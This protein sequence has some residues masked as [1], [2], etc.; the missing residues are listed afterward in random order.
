MYTTTTNRIT[1]AIVETVRPTMLE[2]YKRTTDVTKFGF[3]FDAN[4]QLFY[5]R[6][7]ELDDAVQGMLSC[8]SIAKFRKEHGE[9]IKSMGFLLD[10]N[11]HLVPLKA[12]PERFAELM[13][14][15]LGDT[16]QLICAEDCALKACLKALDKGSNEEIRAI[17]TFIESE[18]G[19][20]R[21]IVAAPWRIALSKLYSV[22]IDKQFAVD[23]L[24]RA[25]P[26][27]V[28][29]LVMVIN[30][31]AKHLRI[32]MPGDW[33]DNALKYAYLL[34]RAYYA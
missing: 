34:A 17:R 2:I 22:F 10:N 7:K 13:I 25:E 24:N 16:H 23:A 18:D 20:E 30:I 3:E 27:Q 1:D 32:N 12:M 29:G 14:N 21:L 33:Y 4:G 31:F 6:D 8:M 19:M 5:P 9:D 15:P 11:G 26:I 28:L